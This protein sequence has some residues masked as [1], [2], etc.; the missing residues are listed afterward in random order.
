MTAPPSTAESA[1]TRAGPERLVSTILFVG[2]VVTA[3]YLFFRVIEP[4]VGGLAWASVLAI[5]VQPLYV[6]FK[7][8]F[9]P[10]L[11]ALLTT[12]LVAVTV[13]VP[14]AFLVIG[15]AAECINLAGRVASIDPS[16]S[17]RFIQSVQQFWLR[18]QSR[19]PALQGIDPIDSLKQ[20]VVGI[21]REVASGAGVLAQNVLSS[22]GLA[23]F[24][25]L[26]LFFLLKNGPALVSYLRRLSP[27]SLETTDRLFEEIRVLTE[28]SVTATLLI[29]SVQGVLGGA[30]AA[31]LRLPAPLIWGTIF[32]FS[33][34]VPVIGT[35]LAW[36]P[37]VAWLAATGHTGKAAIMFFVSILVIAQADNVLR[38]ALV[39]G[40]SRLN[41]EL[42]ML[43]VLGG[44]AA[45][46]MLGLV[47][48]PVIVAVLTALMDLYRDS[49]IV[50]E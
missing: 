49:K 11:S 32:A 10:A 18:L 33:S 22:I 40:R 41:F 31:I 44:V 47:L 25:L 21:S 35:T 15:L 46:G 20:N 23:I 2:L 29:A 39:S 14:A 28:S 27:L 4:F 6:R 7:R 43:S 19:F 16:T 12:S 1:L 45:F 30:A 37:A 38:P 9:A 36:I 5:A 48:G 26:A 34:F 24:V 42:S 17:V 8:R 13:L 3:G 50:P